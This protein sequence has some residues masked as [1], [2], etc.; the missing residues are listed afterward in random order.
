M[1]ENM[2]VGESK[3]LSEAE[4]L[5]T[6]LPAGGPKRNPAAMQRRKRQGRAFKNTENWSEKRKRSQDDPSILVCEAPPSSQSVLPDIK[7]GF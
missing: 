1:L 4:T 3:L 7:V 5:I 6:W 2:I